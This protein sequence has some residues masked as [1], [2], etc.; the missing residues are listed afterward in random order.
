VALP[1]GLNLAALAFLA[2]VVAAGAEPGRLAGRWEGWIWSAG[3]AL[4]VGTLALRFPRAA[5]LPL[6]ALVCLG[7]WLLG[8]ALAPFTVPGPGQ[9]SLRV[10]P[11]TDRELVTAF[12]LRV[13]ELDP[14]DGIPF[15]PDRLVRLRA[16]ESPPPEAWWSWAEARGWARSVAVPP[17]VEPLKFGLYRLVLADGRPHWRLEAPAL[18]PPGPEASP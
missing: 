16:G 10:Q 18:A 5:G 9:P 3:P 15:V 13:D 12:P 2:A 17:P 7:V 6:G 11:L 4:V 1:L 14:P 8:S